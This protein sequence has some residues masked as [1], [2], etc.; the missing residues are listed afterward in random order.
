MRLSCS[1]LVVILLV[2]IFAQSRLKGIA[3]NRRKRISEDLYDASEQRQQA[4]SD[5]NGMEYV[6]DG[7]IH[8][9]RGGY[10]NYPNEHVFNNDVNYKNGY[11]ES[12]IVDGTQEEL[13][14]IA[15]LAKS[16]KRLANTLNH[17][18][19]GD[20]IK[21]IELPY[22][23]GKDNDN[24]MLKEKQENEDNYKNGNDRA[25]RPAYHRDRIIVDEKPDFSIQET[26]SEMG[27]HVRVSSDGT[28]FKPLGGQPTGPLGIKQELERQYGDYFSPNAKE[29]L[30]WEEPQLMKN[31]WTQAM[32]NYLYGFSPSCNED[33]SFSPKQCSLQ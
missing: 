5:V 25:Q 8:K 21:I 4:A 19:N 6:Y 32:L 18:H 10:E 16:D 14:Q 3:K 12:I 31:C 1:F 22:N 7:D 24:M 9:T 30:R 17:L 28:E 33:G 27:P 20:K 11:K 23:R 2:G 29:E 26:G 15:Q 13:D